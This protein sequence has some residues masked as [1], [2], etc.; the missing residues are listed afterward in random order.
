MTDRPMSPMQLAFHYLGELVN[1]NSGE[2][3][4]LDGPLDVT[5]LRRAI[6][7]ALQRHPLLNCVPIKKRGKVFWRR[8]DTPLPIDLRVHHTRESCEANLLPELWRNLWDEPLPQDGR[9]V[10]FV[11]TEGP[12]RSYLQICAP[13]TVTDACSGTR[14]AADI[15]LAYT[16][17]QLGEPWQAEPVAPLERPAAEVFLS[18]LSVVQRFSVALETS[19]RIIRDVFTRGSGLHLASTTKPGATTVTVTEVSED[20][21]QRTLT[22]ARRHHTTAHSVFL[23]ALTRARSEFLGKR[24]EEHFRINDFATLRP[25][26]DR[27]LSDA[28]DVL[29]VPNQISIDP[30]WDDSTVLRRVSK[31]MQAQKDGAILSELYRLSLYGFLGRFLPTRMTAGLVFKH[32]NKTDLAVTNPGR[33]PWQ[34]SLS[35]FGDVEVLDFLN[36]PHLLPP[37]KAVLIFTTFRGRLRVVQLH[38]SRATPEG[39][40]QTVV[41]PFIRHLSDLVGSLSSTAPVVEEA[42]AV[43]G[44][45]AMPLTGFRRRQFNS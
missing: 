25:F 45:A 33:V 18:G 13:H 40:E 17:L 4:T 43:V 42:V 36:F 38:D 34:D 27:D 21:L 1:P 7:R 6:D 22:Q 19:R 2:L 44:P 41:E 9:Q 12:Q 15:A 10:R 26:A 31:R 3:I 11:Y 28:F 37:A 39:I 30:N 20:L 14:L 16:A 29:V 5:L 35:R 24:G 23:L 32:I 8:S